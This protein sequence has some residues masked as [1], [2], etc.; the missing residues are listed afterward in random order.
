MIRRS[1]CTIILVFACAPAM[2]AG[3]EGD[4][5]ILGGNGSC[6]TSDKDH[7]AAKKLIERGRKGSPL[8]CVAFTPNDEWVTLVG[9]NEFYNSD[10]LPVSQKLSEW[11]KNH[12]IKEYRCVAFTPHGGWVALTDT[13]IYATESIPEAAA[14]KLGEL[15][16]AG[17]DIRSIAFTPSGGWVILEGDS[18]AWHNGIPAEA[19]KKLDAL[20]AEKTR[21]ICTAFDYRGN[22]VFLTANNGV[23]TNNAELPVVKRIH[24]LSNQKSTL[25]WVAFTPGEYP[26]EY[27]ILRQPTDYLKAVLTTDFTHPK[28][29]VEE[30]IIYGPVAPE[31]GGQREMKTTLIPGGKIVDELSVLK[32]PLLLARITDAPKQLHT[33]LTFEGTLVARQMVPAIPGRK[34]PPALSE[35]DF[36]HFT[37]ASE[38]VNFEDKAF[39]QWL[40][41][42][43]LR[44]AK[45][46]RD[47]TFARRAYS[48]IRH[49]F[50]Y[51][52]PAPDNGHVTSVCELGKSDCGGLSCAMIATLRANGIPARMLL[53]RWAA[54][55]PPADKTTGEIYGNWHVKSEFFAAGTGWVPLDM[56]AAV[57]DKDRGEFA[58]FGNDHG[59]FITMF[60]D[61]DYELD[62]F[63][64]GKSRGYGMQGLAWWFKGD[65]VGDIKTKEYWSVTKEPVK[66]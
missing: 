58:H 33:T 40:D 9:G 57:T 28:G 39:Q 23:E 19:A 20:V 17:S 3:P 6:W 46:E 15:A 42:Y 18:G 36:K 41:K 10:D 52:Y 44:R 48:F 49:H 26:G 12:D 62:T 13:S 43:K 59:D 35:V 27:T 22:W 8:N 30:W 32:R 7:P 1:F 29:K 2:A 64:S 55:Q 5:F 45:D 61:Q 25:K 56:A 51:E 24:Q 37:R 34:A 54:T 38:S 60:P 50:E 16:K 21:V 4:W 65:G 31:F 14:K 53:G 11:W 66:K 63:V 47:I